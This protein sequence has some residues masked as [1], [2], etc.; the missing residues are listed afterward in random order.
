MLSKIN[1]SREEN[2]RE[3][4]SLVSGKKP[5]VLAAKLL[6]VHSYKLGLEFVICSKIYL[7]KTCMSSPDEFA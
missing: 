4:T 3:L 5:D 1:L 6:N 2:L 7:K